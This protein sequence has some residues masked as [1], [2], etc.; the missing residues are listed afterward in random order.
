MVN[1]STPNNCLLFIEEIINLWNYDVVHGKP[2]QYSIID[3]I[4][5][6]FNRTPEIVTYTER[7]ST[8]FMN[9][10]SRCVMSVWVFDEE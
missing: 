10:M 4:I 9:E 2:K 1:N 3:Q 8:V 6:G 5:S 7:I